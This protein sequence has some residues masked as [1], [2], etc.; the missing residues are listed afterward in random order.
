VAKNQDSVLNLVFLLL[1]NEMQAKGFRILDY[2]L[3]KFLV[4]LA[5][6]ERSLDLNV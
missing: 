5:E 2:S 4:N 1:L 6:L 3:T